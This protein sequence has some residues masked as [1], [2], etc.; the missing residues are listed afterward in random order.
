MVHFDLSR[1]S[2]VSPAKIKQEQKVIEENLKL[3]EEKMAIS[4][5][6][7]YLLHLCEELK[8]KVE[9]LDCELKVWWKAGFL[10]LCLCSLLSKSY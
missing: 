5:E 3:K 2:S 4:E 8:S 7:Q 6:N 1:A 10:I 9:K